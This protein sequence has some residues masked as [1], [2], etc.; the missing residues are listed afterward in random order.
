M[1]NDAL[2]L[3]IFSS[4]KGPKLGNIIKSPSLSCTFI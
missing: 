1:S 4:I 3:V 2:Q